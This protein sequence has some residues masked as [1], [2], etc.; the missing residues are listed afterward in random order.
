MEV[1]TVFDILPTKS[2]CLDQLFPV[3]EYGVLQNILQ[4]TI[5]MFYVGSLSIKIYFILETY[6]FQ[7]KVDPKMLTDLARLDVKHWM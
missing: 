5:Y 6:K 1:H 7:I 3:T 2:M 4:S